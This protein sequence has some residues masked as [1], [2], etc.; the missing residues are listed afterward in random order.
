M[1]KN[2]KK[3]D[4]GKNFIHVQFYQITVNLT[5][6]AKEHKDSFSKKLYESC[7]YSILNLLIA[8]CIIFLLHDTYCLV[9][10][11]VSVDQTWLMH[12][13]KYIIALKKYFSLIIKKGKIMK[14]GSKRVF[15]KALFYY[16]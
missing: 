12:V 6:I 3:V 14:S 16:T 1:K 11:H 10:Q 15:Y 9:F 8:I 7:K 2:I 13:A 5:S 4:K